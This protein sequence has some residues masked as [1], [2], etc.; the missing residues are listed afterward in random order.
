M[1]VKF[2]NY[3]LRIPIYVDGEITDQYRD[4]MSNGT[5]T[6]KELSKELREVLKDMSITHVRNEELTGFIIG[7]GIWDELEVEIFTSNGTKLKELSLGE[8]FIQHQAYLIR[9]S[10][11]ISG[12]EKPSLD[13]C[14]NIGAK[15]PSLT[16]KLEDSVQPELTVATGIMH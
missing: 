14:I 4:Y 1:E 15:L 6:L 3:V 13:G 9:E 2:T 5:K 11:K 8:A 7:L 16:A 12:T 10:A